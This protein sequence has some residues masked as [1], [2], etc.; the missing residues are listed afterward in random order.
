MSYDA[1]CFHPDTQAILF[2]CKEWYEVQHMPFMD[3]LGIFIRSGREGGY[4]HTRGKQISGSDCVLIH[5]TLKSGYGYNH[6]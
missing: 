4:F 5:K 1:S 3:L 6:R 2:T